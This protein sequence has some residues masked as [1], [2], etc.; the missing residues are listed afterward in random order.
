MW[1]VARSEE[2]A[3]VLRAIRGVLGWMFAAGATARWARS[4]SRGASPH[5]DDILRE[6]SGRELAKRLE[7]GVGI[8]ALV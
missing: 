8:G 4:S 2:P 6:L 7:G 3:T 1:F 5:T